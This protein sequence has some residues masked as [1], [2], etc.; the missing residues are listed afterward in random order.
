[1]PLN[2]FPSPPPSS[3]AW[4]FAIDVGGTFTDCVAIAPGGAIRTF[5]TLSSGRTK[6]RI[7]RLETPSSFF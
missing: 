1:M 7:E 4:Q 5:K 2:D 6:G 3:P